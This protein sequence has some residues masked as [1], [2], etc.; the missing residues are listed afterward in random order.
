M[1]N[2]K[3]LVFDVFG[4]V[5]DWRASVIAEGMT[6]GCEKGLNIDWAEFTDRWRLG[7]QPAMEKVRTG[8]LPWTR[9][10]DLHRMILDE[11]LEE[12]HI[13]GLS[14]GGKTIVEPCLASP[15]SVARLRGGAHP[16][17]AEVH[18]RPPVQR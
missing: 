14:G 18:H 1:H 7:Y 12:F 6:W 4:T 5:V 16:L 2:V 13:T 9:L 10:D 17:E 8:K 15:Q 11:L 3:A